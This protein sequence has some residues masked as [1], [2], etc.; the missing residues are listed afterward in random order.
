MSLYTTTGV[1]LLDGEG[2]RILAKYYGKNAYPTVKEQKA[3]EKGLFEKTRR[4]SGK[5]VKIATTEQQIFVALPARLIHL[6]IIRR[7]NSI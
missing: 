2:N 3:F 4:A 7:D 6:L 1:L 5:L